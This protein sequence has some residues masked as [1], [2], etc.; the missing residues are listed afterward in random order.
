MG[1]TAGF[2]GTKRH[3]FELFWHRLPQPR[4]LCEPG[5]KLVEWLNTLEE[6]RDVLQAEFDARPVSEQNLSEWKQ[7]GYQD[8]LRHQEARAY[9][10]ALAEQDG[11]LLDA[12]GGRDIG[13]RF[14]A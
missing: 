5:T 12:A 1:K 7:G 6:V 2:R 13:E 10:H 14:A 3:G 8:W 4:Q 9:V 11:E